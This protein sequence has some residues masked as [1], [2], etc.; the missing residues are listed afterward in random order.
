MKSAMGLGFKSK[1]ETRY[2]HNDDCQIPLTYTKRKDDCTFIRESPGVKKDAT[3][4][5]DFC[6]TY[7]K[8]VKV[9]WVR[10]IYKQRPGSLPLC[11]QKPKTT[12]TLQDKV[13]APL[14][15]WLRSV[16]QESAEKRK[17]RLAGK[18]SRKPPD[19]SS[20]VSRE[21]S[22]IVVHWPSGDPRRL[23]V[24]GEGRARV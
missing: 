13:S 19:R 12:V 18:A 2:E 8:G 6:R 21:S 16:T 23:G 20:E 14:L 24:L 3:E 1:R 17:E 22:V 5:Q 15:Q 7:G 4:M 9:S 11:C 10:Q